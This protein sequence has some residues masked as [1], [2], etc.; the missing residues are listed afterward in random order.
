[1][2]RRPIHP[3]ELQVGQPLPQ[4]AYDARGVL[5]LRKGHVICSDV[6][7]ER[8]VRQATFAE[9]PGEKLAGGAA[10]AGGSDACPLAMVA[11][12]R[13][14][15]EALLQA[16]PSDKFVAE[17]ARIA[18][19]LR[20]ACKRNAD[21][22]LA[23]ILLRREGPYAIRHMVNSAIA[24]QEV[25]AAMN[26]P[27]EELAS[28]VSAA[29]TMNLGMLEL[30][31]ELQSVDMPLTH[32]QHAA[33]QQHCSRSVLLLRERGVDDPL[34]LQTVL[35]H[36]E[37]PDGSGYPAGKT[38][39]AVGVHARLLSLADVYCARV[40]SRDYRP[41]VQ[42]NVALRWLFLNEGTQVDRLLAEKFIKTLGIY[43]P[44]TAVKLRNGSIAVVTHRGASG[45]SPRVA[46]ITTND[47]LRVGMPI[48]RRCDVEAHA[49][50]EVADLEA[51]Q[52]SVSM[53]LLWGS[54]AAA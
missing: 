33:V 28:T 44:G 43:P 10:G 20:R 32:A 19:L 23:S 16:P 38:G 9:T 11:Q 8:L 25:G 52:L 36:H 30:Q 42:P 13:Q 5:M 27:S 21:V 7:I 54:D 29:L 18:T 31:H 15:L 37:R 3:C 34:W 24:C 48:R 39:E 12:A 26:L 51:L 14:R 6:Q 53:E 1:M 2:T 45:S 47:G 46:S 22:A 4:D 35:D 17:L 41:P 40:S 49:V 50:S